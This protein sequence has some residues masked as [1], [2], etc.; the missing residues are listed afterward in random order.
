MGRAR[1]DGG[2]AGLVL[3][4]LVTVM[5]AVA[6]TVVAGVGVAVNDRTRARTA[7][8][9]AALAGAVGGERAAAE[10]A[11]ANGGVLEAFTPVGP[12]VEATVR[13][14]RGRATSRAAPS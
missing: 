1:G 9:A 6:L 12:A 7:A 5:A 14:G 11:V 13:V 8:D 2:Q 10:V 3:V 4:V